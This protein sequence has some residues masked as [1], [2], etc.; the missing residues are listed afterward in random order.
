MKGEIHRWKYKGRKYS[1]DSEDQTLPPAI[2]SL[3]ERQELKTVLEACAAEI[4]KLA[5]KCRDAKG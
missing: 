1:A 5:R 3:Y 2:V 4:L